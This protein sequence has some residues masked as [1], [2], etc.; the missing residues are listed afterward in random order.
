MSEY[1][2]RMREFDWF[3]VR[4]AEGR[5]CAEGP[6]GFKYY[7]VFHRAVRLLNKEIGEL[8]E[9]DEERGEMKYV[10]VR[11]GALVAVMREGLMQIAL[12]LSTV[13]SILGCL[14]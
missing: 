5:A 2:R 14:I 3:I 1:F 9:L 6:V 7:D 8:A 11:R 12:H 10:V 13:R 4:L